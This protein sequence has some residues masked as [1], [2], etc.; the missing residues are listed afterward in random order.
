[1]QNREAAAFV[2]N[3]LM[4]IMNDVIASRN[5]IYEYEKQG[6]VSKEE[7]DTYC[8]NVMGPLDQ[9]LSSVLSPL[10]EAHPGLRP[11]CRGCKTAAE[12]E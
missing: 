5:A 3:A 11:T 7:A 2:T 1:M 12:D 8:L 10:F 9:M 6:K 4:S